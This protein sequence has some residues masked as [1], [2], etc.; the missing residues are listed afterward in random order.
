MIAL[1]LFLSVTNNSWIF[2]TTGPQCHSSHA[3]LKAITLSAE[4]L[5]PSLCFGKWSA[6]LGR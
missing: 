5:W 1:G 4:N 6:E 3:M 2:S